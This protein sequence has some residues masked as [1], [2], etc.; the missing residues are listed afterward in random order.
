VGAGG[1]KAAIFKRLAALWAFYGYGGKVVK[2][3]RLR[4]HA[5]E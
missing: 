2:R 4:A 5:H 3:G 1:Q